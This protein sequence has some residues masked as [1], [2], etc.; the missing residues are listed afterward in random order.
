LAVAGSII[1]ASRAPNRAGPGTDLQQAHRATLAGSRRNRRWRSSCP[2]GT[3]RCRPRLRA[4]LCRFPRRHWRLNPRLPIRFGRF[5]CKG[6]RPA[7]FR[8]SGRRLHL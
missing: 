4:W 6:L 5:T 2:P 8:R 7:Q 3:R 1:A